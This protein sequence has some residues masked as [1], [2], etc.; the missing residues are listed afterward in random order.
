[1]KRILSFLLAFSTCHAKS[2]ITEDF[3]NKVA[4]IESNLKTDAVGDGGE[5][6]GAF[7]I[8]RRAWGDAVAYSRINAGPHDYALPEDWKG[9]AHDFEMSS[10]AAKFILK[11]YEERMIKNKIK[12]T[13]FKLYM[14]YNMGYVGASQH[15]FDIK[16]T[17]GLRR[18][19][20]TRANLILSR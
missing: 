10:C 13:H 16:Q 15:G 5:S 14:A 19:I 4:I 12:P 1:M 11:M 9:W 20:L 8:S 17:W 2:I 7:Q 18:A 3:V 6:L